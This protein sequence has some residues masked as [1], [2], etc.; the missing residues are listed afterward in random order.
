MITAG[1]AV[2]LIFIRTDPPCLQGRV[3]G[4]SS[5]LGVLHGEELYGEMLLR[6]FSGLLAVGAASLQPLS[7]GGGD[8]L[9]GGKKTCGKGWMGGFPQH[10]WLFALVPA[11]CGASREP[12]GKET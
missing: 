3:S 2:L 1:I 5:Q 9:K 12:C 6:D 7:P 10:S 8:T 11:W 4:K